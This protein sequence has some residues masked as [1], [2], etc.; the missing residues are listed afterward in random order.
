MT[1]NYVQRTG[2]LYRPNGTLLAHGY[3][4]FGAGLNNPNM[5]SVTAI[6]PLPVGTYKIGD[7]YDHPHLGPCVMNLYYVE[8]PGTF[9][10][11]LFRMH[12]DN[13]AHAHTASHGCVIMPPGARM[14]VADSDDG[15]LFVVA[16]P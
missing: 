16:E 8:G 2:A 7:S 9:G 12:G 11:S 4:G 10:R 13:S 6:G 15:V 14:E 3:S 1:W 5:Q